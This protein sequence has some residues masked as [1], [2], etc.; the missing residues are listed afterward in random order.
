MLKHSP[1]T[2]PWYSVAGEGR[3]GCFILRIFLMSLS[4]FFAVPV[5]WRCF[6]ALSH[7]II[8]PTYADVY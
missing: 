1:E 4:A 3:V 6:K 8:L 5:M 2:N 7:L